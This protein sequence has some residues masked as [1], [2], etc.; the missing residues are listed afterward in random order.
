MHLLY[1]CPR[2]RRALNR[3]GSGQ[4]KALRAGTR[5]P[6]GHPRP[7][8]FAPWRET[9][10]LFQGLLHG[11]FSVE[12]PGEPELSRIPDAAGPLSPASTIL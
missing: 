5:K 7:R 8:D 6:G 11:L 10:L 3:D 12:M 1:R 9:P 4:S 2:R